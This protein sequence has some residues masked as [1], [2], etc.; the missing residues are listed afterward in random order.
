MKT[1]E[2][3]QGQM[4]IVDDEVFEVVNRWKWHYN[5][6]YAVSDISYVGYG[7][8]RGIH[9]I[10]MHRWVLDSFYNI[11]IGGLQVDHINGVKTDNRLV[12]LRVVT[13]QQNRFNTNQPR[14]NTSGFK[15][16]SF[17]KAVGKYGAWI[18]H[19][20]R[21]HF[22]GYYRV[23]EEAALAYNQAALK[24]HGEYARLNEV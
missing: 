1:V 7:G 17:D 3:T 6:G 23:V 16:V 22:L 20:G 10:Y 8:R 14:N 24:Y 19:D 4:A 12:N 21:K 2:L 5:K 15:G 9:K 13:S 11:R 18:K